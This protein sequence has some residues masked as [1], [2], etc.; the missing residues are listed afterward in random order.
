MASGRELPGL[1]VY[2]NIGAPDSQVSGLASQLQ[3]SEAVQ[4][5]VLTSPEE[6]LNQ[7]LAQSD[8]SEFLRTALAA[9]ETNPLPASFSV[10]LQADTSFLQLDALSRQVL[11]MPGVDDVEIQSAWIERLRDLGKL[12]N[13]IG[14]GLSVIL[15]V[16]AVLVTFASVRLAIESKLA[17]LAG[18]S[19]GRR[20]G[21]ADA[22]A[23][24]LLWCFLWGW[25]RHYGDFAHCAVSRPN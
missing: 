23:V 5:I 15:L 6:A 10:V 14:G 3:E 22:A 16:A 2:M 25:R 13:R 20:Y 17:E 21:I 9:I 18:V 8:D 1:T 12:A 4:R 24:F 19:I 11:A 7:L